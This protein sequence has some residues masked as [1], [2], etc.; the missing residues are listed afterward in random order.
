MDD[1]SLRTR[2][3]A[4]SQLLV[5][6][7][8]DLDLE[9]LSLR[10]DRRR[11]R[12]RLTAASVGL[13]LTVTLV[14]GALAGLHLAS[15]STNADAAGGGLSGSVSEPALLAGQYLY[16]DRTEVAPGGLIVTETWWTTD[17]SGRLAFDCTIPD[18]SN[19]YGAPPTGTFDAGKFPTDDNVSGLSADPSVL[20][21]QLEQRTAPGGRSPEPP[22][23]PGPELTPG[24]TAGSLWDA[25]TNIL[26]DPTG[27]PDLRAAL[28]DV[29]YGIPGVQVQTDVTDP[30]GRAAIALELATPGGGAPAT[31][32]F[33]PSTHQLM[34]EGEPP[35]TIGSSGY[36]LYSEGIVSSI[37]T[38]PSGAQWLFPPAQGLAAT[39]HP[40]G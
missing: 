34:A 19:A 16:L 18:C 7:D 28:F 24:V 17:D 15:R 5:P 33:D 31:L 1:A 38:T 8:P 36:T 29:A 21:Q 12:E 9:W 32:Y 20:L 10:R 2:L 14:V 26:E 40:T 37:D 4:A 6:P 13:I 39:G 22:F 30:A 11:R 25:V 23:S 27:G 3:R 35:G